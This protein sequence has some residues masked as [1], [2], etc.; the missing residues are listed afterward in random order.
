MSLRPAWATWWEPV[1]KQLQEEWKQSQEEASVDLQWAGSPAGEPLDIG[2]LWKKASHDQQHSLDWFLSGRSI[3]PSSVQ[4]Q[5]SIF[6]HS[7]YVLTELK[8]FHRSACSYCLKMHSADVYGRF[9]FLPVCWRIVKM[10]CEHVTRV[11]ALVPGRELYTTSLLPRFFIFSLLWCCGLITCMP[12]WAGARAQWILN[13]LELEQ[14]KECA[15]G[16]PQVT[17]GHAISIRQQPVRQLNLQSAP[18]HPAGCL[19]PTPLPWA[20]QPLQVAAQVSNHPHHLTFR[21]FS[22]SLLHHSPRFL[23][24]L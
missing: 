9:G 3:S 12:W 15:E 4:A 18:L 14:R 16:W 13:Y 19:L 17:P 11:L 5:C 1:L 10:D 8:V 23:Y 20:T 24:V 21:V 22:L 6:I 2:S 7:V